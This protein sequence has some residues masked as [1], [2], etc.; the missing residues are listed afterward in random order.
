MV[1]K[2]Q[3]EINLLQ[4]FAHPQNVECFFYNFCYCCCAK[5]S[6]IGNELFIF[7]KLP[8][9]S[10]LLVPP[11]P[12]RCSDVPESTYTVTRKKHGHIIRVA[13]IGSN[14]DVRCKSCELWSY[15][16]SA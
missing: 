4:L 16:D 1:Y 9:P 15:V 8:L 2:D 5:T 14:A 3:L 10:T 7:Y 13:S 6:I 12:Y 11:L